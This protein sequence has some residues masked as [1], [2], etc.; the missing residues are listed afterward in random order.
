MNFK[1]TLVAAISKNNGIGKNN[2][3]PWPHNA[4][5]M[6]WF[7]HITSHIE[8]LH[9]SNV[10][11]MGKNTWLSMNKRYLK[12]RWNIVI[13]ST[14]TPITNSNIDDGPSFSIC[15]NLMEAFR[16]INKFQKYVGEV[17]VIGGEKLYYDTIGLAIT[18][19]LYIT[20]FKQN[21][22]C[23]K[24]FPKIKQSDYCISRVIES[25]NIFD[26]VEYT[27]IGCDTEYT[28]LD[29]LEDIMKEGADRIDRTGVGTLSKFGI[30]IRHTF[31]YGSIPVLTTKN[32]FL[33]GVFEELLWFLRGSTNV[34]D[35][36]EKDVHIWDG[37]SSREFL[38]KSGLTNR[39]EGDIGPTYGFNFRH[40]GAEY[41]DCLSD[42]TGKGVDQLQEV[43]KDIKAG[44]TSRRMI[45]NLWNPSVLNEMALP[46]CLFCYQFYVA[47]GTLS[48]MTTQ[49]SGDMGLGVPFNLVSASILVYILAKLCDLEPGELIHNIGDAHV[50]KNH[51][52]PLNKQLTRDPRPF[53]ILQINPTK[54]FTKIEDFKVEDFN[55]L[56]YYP[57]PG[58]K[59]EMAV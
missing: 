43:I 21:Y 55:I 17:F 42:Y 27:N 40:F 10:V 16:E 33:K 18:E 14:L 20:H 44:G 30:Q 58:I 9:R 26:I 23:D 15:S 31:Q 25:N 52:E 28:Y 13:S 57:Y 50:Y 24:F 45:I 8:G 41:I 56:G 2:A 36:Q 32:V 38:D 48:C 29:T 6:K 22:E 54:T 51:I 5:D 35:L 49:R 46:P 1:L 53:P 37:N 59:M 47:N 3:I 12:N 11:I 34:K 4:A 7:Q 39:I 19:T